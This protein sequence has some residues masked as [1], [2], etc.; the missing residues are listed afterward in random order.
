MKRT[1]QIAFALLCAFLLAFGCSEL[2]EPVEANLEPELS[3]HP[4][5]WG[6]PPGDPNFHGTF[7][8]A[9]Q[10]DLAGCRECHGEDY[11]GGIS[12]SSCLPCHEQTPE[13]CTVCHGGADNLTGA[14]P[15]DL[16]GN[17]ATDARG[18]GAHTV[19]LQGGEL[20]DGFDCSSCHIVPAFDAPEHIDANLPAELNFAGLALADTAMPAWNTSSLSCADSYCHGNWSLSRSESQRMNFYVENQ[21]RGNN[22]SPVWTDP[23]TAE[24]GTCHDLPPAGHTPFPVEQCAN[25]HR[26]VVDSEL[27]IIDKTKHVNGM[28]NVFGTE[29]P[30]F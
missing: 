12:N 18:V 11:A 1:P 23:E 14:P 17:T 7:L 6:L 22:A 3:V 9:R 20:A 2:D 28:I 26:L 4:Q 16:A 10:W 19:H 13:D 27:N 8:S 15:E 21:M 5:G 25:C 29:E 30:I 24:C